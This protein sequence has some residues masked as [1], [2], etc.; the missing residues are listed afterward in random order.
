MKAHNQPRLFLGTVGVATDRKLARCRERLVGG[1]PSALDRALLVELEELLDFP[2]AVAVEVPRSTDLAFDVV[3]DAYRFGNATDLSLGAADLPMYWRSKV[4]LSARLY[5]LQSNQT[6]ATLR[7]TQKMP[8]LT[9][10]S[11]VLSWR[12][13]LGLEQP[14]RRSELQALLRQAGEK[15][16]SGLR[17]ATT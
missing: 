10:F 14:S 1:S 2:R 8:W 11:R 9:F 15:L 4:R 17:E 16:I 5:G 3:L 12:V 6:K 13:L 7:V